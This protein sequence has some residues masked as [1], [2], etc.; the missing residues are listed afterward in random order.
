VIT[1]SEFTTTAEV[2]SR[3]MIASGVVELLLA[4]QDRQTLPAWSPGAHI[5]LLLPDGTSRQYSL[6]G[7]VG[8]LRTYRIAV[9]EEPDGRG[10]SRRVH[11]EAV[12]GSTWAVRGPRS[13]FEFA[14]SPNYL[15]IAGGIGI[16]PL[17]PM[18]HSA[19]A[20]GARWRLLYGGRRRASMAF[21][22]ELEQFEDQVTISPESENGLLP[23]HQ[24][25]ADPQPDTLI[26]SCGPG[27]L[28]QAVEDAARHWPPKSLRSE[29][30]SPLPL[31][32]AVDTPFEVKLAKSDRVLQ[33]PTGK[34]I[35]DVVREADIP[36]L[37]ACQSGT[38]GTCET[39]VLEGVPDHRD[40]VLDADERAANDY[41]MICVSRASTRRLVLDL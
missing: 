15:F 7:D 37:S 39:P 23:L 5:D 28:L 32:D 27:P 24:W 30:F 1:T 35:L 31:G 11:Q 8:D 9:L 26:Y 40:S 17:L 22:D 16:T 34:S 14:D 33:V 21:T 13:Y 29:R 41:M 36:T 12:V 2:V 20:S 3:R 4:R 18:V 19:R 6:C 25:L 10:F 38:C